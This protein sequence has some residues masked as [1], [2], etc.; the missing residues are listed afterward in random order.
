VRP[1]IDIA[2]R[3]GPARPGAA[4]SP[5]YKVLA[6]AMRKLTVLLATAGLLLTSGFVGSA[7]AGELVRT[8]STLKFRVGSLP[9]TAV[10]ALPGSESLVTL[11]NGSILGTATGHNILVSST[12]WSTVNFGV[13]TSLFTGVPLISNLKVTAGNQAGLLQD[14]AFATVTNQIGGGG[15]LGPTFG[16]ILRLSGSI[17]IWVGGVPEGSGNGLQIPVPLDH[18]GGQ[19]GETTTVSL[20]GGSIKA[21]LGP[22]I[23]APWVITGLTTNQITIP[24]RG[25]AVGVAF[26]LQPTPNENPRTPT[27]GNGFVSTHLTPSIAPRVEIATITTTGTNNLAS[28]SQTGSVTV[29]APL[30]IVTGSI[31]GTLPGATDLH[32]EFVPEPGTLLL[33]V[34]GAAGLVLIGRRRMRK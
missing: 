10:A 1:G 15:N 30:R 2:V 12:V 5:D 26:T 7:Q 19:M 11:D 31:A 16:G 13:G 6:E 33:L 29:I 32:F 14:G 21:T 18:V 4:G 23:T 25:N 3:E 17:I 34:S 20:L 24:E 22:F 28:A 27:T 8:A 9:I